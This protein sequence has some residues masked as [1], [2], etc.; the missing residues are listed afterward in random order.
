V[1]YVCGVTT[2]R[3]KILLIFSYKFI[4]TRSPIYF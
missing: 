3:V 4:F 1:A 2:E